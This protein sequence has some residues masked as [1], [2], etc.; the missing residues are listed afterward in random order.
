[1]ALLYAGGDAL[2]IVF[3]GASG[4]PPILSVADA[5]YLGALAP[6]VVGLLIYPTARGLRRTLGPLVLDG[7]VLGAS[8]LLLSG[9]LALEEVARTTSGRETFMYVVYPI[10]DVLLTC[11]VVVLLLRSA[12]RTRADVLL[13]GAT[14]A[15]YTVADNTYALT[16]VGGPDLTAFYNLAYV[17]APLL[18]SVAALVAAAFPTRARILQRDLPGR[19]APV[20]P[21]LTAFVA[22]GTCLGAALT[23]RTEIALV[24][25]VLVLTGLRQMA[26]TA[27]NLKLRHDL[28]RRVDDRTEEL[29][30]LTEEHRRLDAMKQEFVSAVSHELRT[31]LTA[32]RGSLEMLADGEAGDLPPRARPVVEMATRGSERLS[33]LVNDIIDLER[34]ESGTFGFHPAVHDLHPLIQD[35]GDSL[36]PLAQEAGVALVVSP[37]RLRVTCDGDRV[38]Q[39]LVN[40]VG[41]ALKFTPA[42]G[43]VTVVAELTGAEVRISV[44]DT[45]R[46]IPSQELSAIFDRFHQIDPD[47]ARQKAGT[48]LGL[49]ITERI[50]HGHGGRIWVDS[51]PGRGSTFS[52]TLPVPEV[53][54]VRRPV[55]ALPEAAAAS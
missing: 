32:I 2:W 28:M 47:D 31:P 50:V 8:V 51:T 13:L 6:A 37:L 11:L 41:N 42:G 33:R 5:L 3:G 15:T 7:L 26:L 23:A 39:A 46:G 38:T 44:C 40:L 14:F 34:L 53:V 36:T 54:V 43:T 19:L 45:G 22:L 52:F 25:A 55:G 18:L 24:T 1:M 27:Q 21:D 16:A 29:R 17:V 20:L 10:T 12:G 49:A 35:V 48:G 30:L 4:S 9:V